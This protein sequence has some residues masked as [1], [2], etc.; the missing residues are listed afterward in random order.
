MSRRLVEPQVKELE[1]RMAA[2][3]VGISQVLG[4]RGGLAGDGPELP[5]NVS[6]VS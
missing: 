4:G 3:L 2:Q 6:E 5:D 1:R